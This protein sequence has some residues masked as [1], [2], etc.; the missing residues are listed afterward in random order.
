MEN[1]I[2]RILVVEDEE[3]LASMLRLNLEM[4]GYQVVVCYDGPTALEKLRHQAFDLAILD[5]MI[6]E[7]DGFAVCQTIRL[8][9]HKTPI[10]FLSAKSSGKDRVEGLKIGGDDY[11]RLRRTASSGRKIDCPKR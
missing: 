9:G 4:D 3:S 7:L 11:V 10:L 6:P 1:S 5:V 8:E 2:Y